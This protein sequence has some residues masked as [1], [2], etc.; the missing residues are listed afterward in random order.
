MSPPCHCK[1]LFVIATWWP[2]TWGSQHFKPSDLAWISLKKNMGYGEPMVFSWGR[3]GW[4]W[5]GGLLLR[6]P[7]SNAN[8]EVGETPSP[9]N[10]KNKV[11]IHHCRRNQNTT[12]GKK[13][14]L[15]PSAQNDSVQ[16]ITTLAQQHW[17]WCE[18][19]VTNFPAVWVHWNDGHPWKGTPLQRGDPYPWFIQKKN[20]QDMMFQF[21]V[22]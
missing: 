8:C 14:G 3:G 5:G 9:K 19:Q 12:L 18:F 6:F 10:K 1:V 21:P 22:S 11:R 20:V 2:W 15:V 4:H 13:L 16:N 7:W 17:R